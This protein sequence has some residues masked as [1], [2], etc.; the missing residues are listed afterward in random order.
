[1]KL[2]TIKGTRRGWIKNKV[3]E[4]EIFKRNKFTFEMIGCIT[5]AY[6]LV[7]RMKAAH[8]SISI[9]LTIEKYL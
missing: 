2:N 3:K 8:R 1:M 4:D 6:L 9:S 5:A 7:F